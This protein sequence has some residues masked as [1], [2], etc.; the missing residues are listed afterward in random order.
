MTQLETF[1]KACETSYITRATW[2]VNGRP[3]G[4]SPPEKWNFMRVTLKDKSEFL[5]SKEEMRSLNSE[6]WTGL[7]EKK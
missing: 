3:G 6:R 5:L 2:T 1:L 4:S 7:W